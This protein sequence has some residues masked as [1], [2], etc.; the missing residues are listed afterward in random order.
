MPRS[1]HLTRRA[2]LLGLLQ[3]GAAGAE[4]VQVAAASDLKFVLDELVARYRVT[5]PQADPVNVSY[6]SSGNFFAQIR[7]G[8]PYT[9]YLSAD[10]KYPQELE[11]AGLTVRGT[12]RDYAIGRLVIWVPRGSPLEVAKLGPQV[13]TDPRVRK[14]AI[15]NPQHAPYGEAALGLLRHYGLEQQLR[16]RFVIGENIAVTA[17]YAGA[18]ADAGLLALS[19]VKAPSFQALGGQYWLAPLNT[20]PPLR[21]QMVM[22]KDSPNTRR[23]WGFVASSAARDLFRKYGFLLPGEF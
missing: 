12:R 5:Y 21:Q 18:A 15:A 23:F 6:G 19:I 22:L 9:L 7:N 8:A 1:L 20:H 17:Q 14:V 3:W 13:L 16:P 4:T 11:R 2:A 10:R